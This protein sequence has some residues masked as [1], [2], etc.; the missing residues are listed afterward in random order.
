MYCVCILYL[1]ISN[2]RLKYNPMYQPNH[3]QLVIAH[4]FTVRKVHL[5]KLYKQLVAFLIS[6]ISFGS[7]ILSGPQKNKAI[8]R[9]LL[10]DNLN[11]ERTLKIN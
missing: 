1:L 4:C 7:R 5:H 3:G 9:G 8:V 10:R 11:T 6:K 2:G